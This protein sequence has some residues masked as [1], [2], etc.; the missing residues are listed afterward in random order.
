VTNH[1]SGTKKKG[2]PPLKNQISVENFN[3]TII[4][5]ICMGRVQ[6]AV[7]KQLPVLIYDRQILKSF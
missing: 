3:L 5:P 2:Y 6:V 7:V 4:T 1:P